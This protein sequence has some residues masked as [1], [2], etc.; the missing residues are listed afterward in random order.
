MTHYPNPSKVKTFEEETCAYCQ[1]VFAANQGRCSA[2]EFP[3]E[4]FHVHCL[5]LFKDDNEAI[6][7][8]DKDQ[9]PIKQ[10][11][12]EAEE[13]PIERKIYTQGKRKNAK[14]LSV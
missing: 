7:H 9:L 5:K 4:V 10:P 14:A 8:G 12:K 3:G 11:A 6:Y 13:A 1:L 2:T